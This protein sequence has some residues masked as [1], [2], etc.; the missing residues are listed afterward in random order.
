MT[1]DF[2]L[3]PAIDLRGGRVVRLEQGDFDRE[4][5][6][7][8]DPGAVAARFVASGAPWLHV[9]D[10][11]GARA[12]GAVNGDAVNAIIAAA[13][14][15]AGVDLGGGLRSFEAVASAFDRGVT[16]V[17]LGTAALVD[18]SLV[19]AV[20]RRFG[21]ARI[22][23]A[24]DVRDGLARGEAWRDGAPGAP[25]EEIIDRLASA[26]VETFEVTAIE[27]DGLLGG[28]DLD[29]LDRLVGLNCG[30]IVAS[31]GI[32]R[33]DDI[34]AVRRIGCS[35]AIVGRALYDGSLTMEAAL[36]AATDEAGP[37]PGPG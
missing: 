5:R 2:E 8:D 9:V 23:V 14:G 7:S 12:G 22:A 35:G 32:R 37:A 16:R 33:A 11:D 19:A 25:P 27:R 28:P 10:L 1:R 6:F 31:G 15:I 20:A 24:V 30:R 3:L 29:L 13:R 18:T 34:G 4:T 26:G 21:G 17:V 36:A